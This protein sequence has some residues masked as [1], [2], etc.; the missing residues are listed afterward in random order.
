MAP[1]IGSTTAKVP[2]SCQLSSTGS[3]SRDDERTV[4]MRYV[5]K[6]EPVASVS[7]G[8]VLSAIAPSVQRYIDG[9]LSMPL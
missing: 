7:E 9:D 5:W 1:S 6:I 2:A 3:S 8:Q 4:L